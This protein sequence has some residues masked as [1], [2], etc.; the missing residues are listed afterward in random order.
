MRLLFFQRR[1]YDHV[2]CL[3]V[4]WSLLY[5]VQYYHP[6]MPLC[7][8]QVFFFV[9]FLFLCAN[10]CCLWNPCEPFFLFFFSPQM[11]AQI[12]LVLGKP[13]SCQTAVT[14]CSSSCTRSLKSHFWERQ[15]CCCSTH[16]LRSA[17]LYKTSLFSTL[18]SDNWDLREH[19]QISISCITVPVS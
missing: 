6:S 8:Y 19:E 13:F 5:W 1:S 18:S 16:A 9:D 15:V 3:L 4:T 12:A 2:S 10:R 11:G 17:N 14:T 7:L